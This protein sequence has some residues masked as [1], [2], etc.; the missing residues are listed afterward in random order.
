MEFGEATIGTQT[1]EICLIHDV[2]A[3]RYFDGMEEAEQYAQEHGTGDYIAANHDSI[4]IV[5]A[6]SCIWNGSMDFNPI[7]R[8]ANDD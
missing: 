7:L 4:D 1:F 8:E 6:E 3:V 2:E 5:F